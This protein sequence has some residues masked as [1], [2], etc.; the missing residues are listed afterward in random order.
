MPGDI[1]NNFINMDLDLAHVLMDY[2]VTLRIQP[3][4]SSAR[5]NG[6]TPNTIGDASQDI[7]RVGSI[8]QDNYYDRAR[9]DILQRVFLYHDDVDDARR[10]SNSGGG[11]RV[12]CAG[13]QSGSPEYFETFELSHVEK[14]GIDVPENDM[15]E[16]EWI[17][18]THIAAFMQVLTNQD[19][20]ARRA[21]IAYIHGHH[22]QTMLNPSS[23]EQ[24]YT[25]HNIAGGP[26]S[27][28]RQLNTSIYWMRRFLGYY[29]QD[30]S[31]IE[32]VYFPANVGNN[33]FVTLH[34]DIP[35]KQV[36]YYDSLDFEH[37]VSMAQGQLDIILPAISAIYYPSGPYRWPFRNRS[38]RIQ[39]DTGE[40]VNCGSY[41]ALT[42]ELLRLEDG[43]ATLLPHFERRG[44]Y[45]RYRMAAAIWRIRDGARSSERQS[46]DT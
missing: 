2:V 6:P 45:N 8:C 38:V 10:F 26:G 28:E 3:Q 21:G 32:H 15:T 4:Q 36:L 12:K 29:A 35:R 46:R 24:W 20:E 37:Y 23:R 31:S 27:P 25:Q 22:V 39:R 40:I 19:I 5:Q 11:F 17:G 33:H 16:R 30:I 18:Q 34:I 43:D 9:C 13:Y 44:W 41:V 14:M 1:Q 42:V 7:Q